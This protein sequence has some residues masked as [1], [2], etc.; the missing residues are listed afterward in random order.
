MVVGFVKTRQTGQ[1]F[2]LRCKA[3]LSYLAWRERTLGNPPHPRSCTFLR[4]E[5][6]IN[7]KM[8]YIHIDCVMI[9]TDVLRAIN[10]G[11]SLVSFSLQL[12]SSLLKLWLGFLAVA[13]P[14]GVK[15]DKC[16]VLWLEERQ[17]WWWRQM[18]DVAWCV[19]PCWFLYLGRWFPRTK[20]IVQWDQ[21]KQGKRER[22]ERSYFFMKSIRFWVWRGPS[23]SNANFPFL[24][25]FT[26]TKHVPHIS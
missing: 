7:F 26:E 9:N 18:I 10:S 17:E 21:N 22:V 19:R 20:N 24:K 25:Y 6:T 8:V 2:G 5:K 12:F 23:K 1:S 16:V 14:W 13:A 15:H 11:K 3:K 4:R